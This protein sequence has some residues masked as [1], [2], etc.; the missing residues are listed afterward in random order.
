[1]SVELV[2]LSYKQVGL[3]AS[4]HSIL[5]VLSDLREK[6]RRSGR[7]WIAR[8]AELSMLLILVRRSLLFNIFSDHSNRGTTTACSKIAG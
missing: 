5:N 6:P 3:T 4:E 1:M 7:G 2:N 8:T